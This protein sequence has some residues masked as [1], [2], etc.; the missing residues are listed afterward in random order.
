MVLNLRAEEG[1]QIFY[2]LAERTD[3]ILEGFRPGT[4]KRLGV[5]YET[6]KR[7]NPRMIY[8]S[9]S[10]FGQDGPYSPLAG[11]DP[12]YVAISGAMSLIGPKDKA[13]SLPPNL[14]AD[15]AA[16]G[17]Q[18]ALAILAALIVRERT[19]WGQYLDV[20]MLD[21]IMSLLASELSHYFVSGLVPKRG[22]TWNTGAEPWGSIYETKDGGYITVAAGEPHFWQN[23]CQALGC[24]D[25]IP[26]HEATGE[27]KV[28]IFTRFKEAFLLKTRDEWFDV[29][30]KADVPA[31]PVYT[32][33]EAAGNPHIIHRRMVFEVNHPKLGAVKQ[34]GIIPHLS[35]APGQVRHLGVK[36]GEHT[37][38]VLSSLGYTQ[39]DI[40]QLREKGVIS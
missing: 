2:K 7:Q 24:D 8:C 21:G 15:F 5:D 28:E 6:L 30:A 33:E 32:L 31:G 4:V 20:A 9:L 18:A 22:E 3:V 25:L 36:P 29:L 35:E 14:L 34:V 23:L 11:H 13:P 17:L 1:R 40:D 19:G 10:G 39:D 37:A 26:Y 27:K 12:N 16:G 38:K